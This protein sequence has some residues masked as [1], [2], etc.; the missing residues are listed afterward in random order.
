MFD[1]PFM[2]H[3]FVG[4]LLV[5]LLAGPI[6]WFMLLRRQAFAAHALPHIGFSG[7]AAAIWLGI[8]PLWGM[9]GSSLIAGLL[10][11]QESK[12][13]GGTFAPIRRESMTGLVLAA[14][15]G[16]GVWCLHMANSASNQASTLLF[17]DVLGLS[18][19]TL[20]SL[21][22]IL[23]FCISV[24]G[25]IGRPLLFSSIAPDLAQARGVPI[26]LL[27]RLFMML[28]AFATAACSEVAGALLSFS[29]MIGPASAAL[30]LE[31]SP[32]KGLLFSLV[33]ALCLSWGGLI[34]SWY[35]DAPVAFW[36]GIGAV[37]LYISASIIQHLRQTRRLL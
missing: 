35:T 1:F 7:A 8:A 6:G 13:E 2:Q 10:M 28:A 14:S 5:S 37:A 26:T 4:C 19:H 27:S 30:R 17:G 12:G 16:I 34:L 3:A 11:A 31:L 29:L 23:I 22:G 15:L 32:T 33:S 24:L 21:G 18:A 25:I 20:F 36:I 9:M